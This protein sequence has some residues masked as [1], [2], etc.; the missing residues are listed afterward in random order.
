MIWRTVGQFS[1]NKF[2][3]TRLL[4]LCLKNITHFRYYTLLF[5]CPYVG[6]HIFIPGRGLVT[7]GLN[8]DQG[9]HVTTTFSSSHVVAIILQP[10]CSP[11]LPFWHQKIGPN[12]PISSKPEVVESK[13]K[14]GDIHWYVIQKLWV[15]VW[16]C[17]LKHSWRLINSAQYFNPS[18]IVFIVLNK[19]EKMGS[20][21]LLM[22]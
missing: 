14:K 22:M 4:M 2:E 9:L 6:F 16:H 1:H 7:H 5:K 10:W 12:S 11:F 13:Q 21:A 20:V 19:A 8:S 15:V 3:Y 18:L 17:D